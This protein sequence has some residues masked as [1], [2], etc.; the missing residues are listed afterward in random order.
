MSQG[1]S[2][3]TTSIISTWSPREAAREEGVGEGAEGGGGK[4]LKRRG[5]GRGEG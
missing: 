5:E 2:S 3:T 1:K 4:E